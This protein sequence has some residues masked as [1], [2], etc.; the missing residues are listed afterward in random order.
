MQLSFGVKLFLCLD[1]KTSST[2][3]VSSVKQTLPTQ[4]NAPTDNETTNPLASHGSVQS[5][6]IPT[7]DFLPS[8]ATV[9]VE[10]ESASTENIL[11]LHKA[12]TA[13]CEQISSSDEFDFDDF[14]P[15]ICMFHRN[16]NKPSKEQLCGESENCE[17]SLPCI[18]G[19][20]VDFVVH[21]GENI[22][23]KQNSYM[24]QLVEHERV[25]KKK[26]KNSKE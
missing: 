3:P 13:S 17:V 10:N 26:T 14:D 12:N 7:N 22:Q 4:V 19:E 18:T 8:H 6:N 5:N 25:E 11:P 15:Q 21:C 20:L 23:A 9:E 24:Q 16:G 1:F 2:I